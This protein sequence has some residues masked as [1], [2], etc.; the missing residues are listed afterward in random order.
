MELK[1]STHSEILAR[2]HAPESHSTI[3]R[4]LVLIFTDLYI[5]E[6]AA[7]AQSVPTLPA[8]SAL[9]TRGEAQCCG[10]WRSWILQEVSG[11]RLPKVP[12]AS[13][14]RAGVLREQAHGGV[15]QEWWL[16][17]PVHL[18]A[19][20]TDVRMS[21][22]PVELSSDEWKVL[23]RDF[24][25]LFAADDFHLSAGT[26]FAAF[27]ATSTSIDASTTDPMRVL[28][29]G[30]E[31][32][33]PGG[34]AGKVLRRLMTAAQMWLHEHPLNEARRQRGEREA[35]ALWLWGGG[36]APD[37]FSTRPLPR[38]ASADSYLM[39]LWWLM[40]QSIEPEAGS[41]DTLSADDR[42]SA[43]VSLECMRSSK[44]AER[45]EE[46]DRHWMAPVLRALR[47]G[48]LQS[49][50][51]HMNDQMFRVRWLHALRFWRA[52]RHWLEVVT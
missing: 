46:I 30:V 15:R 19:G 50:V 27:L 11:Q 14:S 21:T 52:P 7:S 2:Q 35:N 34:P 40:K 4:E 16:A 17:T 51:L 1:G 31:P 29:Q 24:N 5:A 13:I 43:V 12:V 20:L 42:E 45:L 8:L 36:P 49:L 33:L 6:G 44:L 47:E 25:Q 22:Q 3:V 37:W 41:F 38:L 39:G 18:D 32:A 28:G 23:V 26:S 9:L 10:D 48:R